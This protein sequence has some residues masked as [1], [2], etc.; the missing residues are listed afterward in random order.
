VTDDIGF[1]RWLASY[2]YP[3]ERRRIRHDGVFAVRLTSDALCSEFRE[4]WNTR[5]EA[6]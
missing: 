3:S 6:F 1:A 2:T 5:E 4:W